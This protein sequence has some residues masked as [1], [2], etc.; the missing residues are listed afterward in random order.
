MSRRPSK[1]EHW[2][3]LCAFGISYGIG[4]WVDLVSPLF[5]GTLWLLLLR[6]VVSGVSYFFLAEFGRKTIVWN[7]KWKAG[8]W[9]YLPAL[10][11]ILLGVLNE[12]GDFQALIRCGLGWPAG[13]L[14][15]FALHR[16]EMLRGE[17]GPRKPMV[18]APL[19]LALY[20]LSSGLMG[21][22]ASFWPANSIHDQWVLITFGV[23][24]ILIRCLLAGYVALAL[25][26]DYSRRR[27]L[28][29]S[30]DLTRR[31]NFV[32][33]AS[34]AAVCFVL[35]AGWMLVEQA[36]QECRQDH[37]RRLSS[38]SRGMAAMLKPENVLR[39]KGSAEEM[40]SPAYLALVKDCQR[41][42]E[43]DPDVRYVYIVTL[44]GDKV[45]FLV[46]TEP[47]RWIGALDKPNAGPGDVYHSPPPE[48]VSAYN[49]G[50]T[51]VS[52]PYRDAWG[53]FVSSF[54]PIVDSAG[55]IIAV[56]GIDE[57]ADRWHS[58]IT[59]ARLARLLLTGGA[60]LLLLIFTALWRL[61]IEE[62]QK[63]HADGQRMQIQQSA[64]LRM[65]NSSFLAEGNVFLMAR[66]VTKVI[67]EVIGV[68]RVEIWLVGKGQDQFRA[69]D[70]YQSDMGT[71]TSGALACISRDD[72]ILGLLE[73]GRVVSSPDFQTDGRFQGFKIDVGHDTCSVLLAPLRLSG[74][75]DGWLMAS[76]SVRGRNWLVDEMRFVAEMAD[77][78]SNSRINCERK[79]AEEALRK[80][81]AELEKRVMERTEALSQK[82]AELVYEIKER[83]RVEEE[84][85]RLQ[86]KMMQTQKLES[87]GL[88]A[89]GIAHDFNNILMAVLGNAE[90]ALLETPADAPTYVYLQ[91]IDKAASRA[92]ELSRQMLIYSGRGHAKIQG[93]DLNDM[94]MDMTSMLKVSLGKGIQLVYE[95]DVKTPVVD[96]DLTQMRQVLMNLV[97]NASEAIGR[98]GGSIILRTGVAHYNK[99]MLSAMWLKPDLTEGDYVFMDVIDEGCGMD[100]ATL[101]RIFDPFF[102]T[103]FTGRGL[104]LAAVLGIIKGHQGDID[105]TSSIGK[106]THFRVILP[107]GN[108]RKEGSAAVAPGGDTVIWKGH[109]TVLLVDDEEEVRIMG[110]R[111]LERMGFT[112]REAKGGREAIDI[113]KHNRGDIRCVLLDMTMPVLDGRE[114]LDGIRAIDP[115]AKVI[116]CSG[117][118][119]THGLGCFAAAHVSG[120]IQKPYKLEALMNLLRE[121][122]G[123]M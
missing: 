64:L 107:V 98:E 54:S 109:G 11:L 93:I 83:L 101:K 87:L 13:I 37:E 89:G 73:E 8:I 108:H 22:P 57:Q 66:A 112:V 63:R 17:A 116:L 34:V 120:F 15:A 78:V 30:A 41:M 92:A 102:T 33:R 14:A 51:L 82:N 110:R 84:Q 65:A 43:V 18:L 122:L 97:I 26:Q 118:S 38:L 79:L 105:V 81:H 49:A 72:P 76:Q 113:F 52:K 86:D 36:E 35:L 99:T 106:G 69:E 74:R 95:L 48:L 91:D 5:N 115:E 103:K 12:P 19:A 60:L 62:S 7:G 50:L 44:R 85:R 88:M 100:E 53:A 45:V 47:L 117:Y 121:T 75:A 119:E 29:Y 67:A 23:P 32:I 25:W 111:M 56:L 104:G 90:L 96:G 70:V 61:E 1:G 24:S 46:D 4:E 31:V 20:I 55:N 80:A 123:A 114:T 2:G 40:H 6:G 9:I 10:I 59:S 77:Q 21:P 42:C 28:N 39:L 68:D 58:D 3:Y 16:V 71:H 27:F 94:I